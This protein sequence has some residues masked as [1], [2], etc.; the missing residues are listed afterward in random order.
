V[1]GAGV[2]GKLGLARQYFLQRDPLLLGAGAQGFVQRVGRRMLRKSSTGWRLG[3]AGRELP[4]RVEPVL[5]SVSPQ[6]AGVL[7]E[8]VGALRDF[9][10]GGDGHGHSD[11]AQAENT[12]NEFR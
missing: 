8:A 2:E 11:I 5:E 6:G 9:F 10:M 1:L 7:P 4:F 12:T 3:W